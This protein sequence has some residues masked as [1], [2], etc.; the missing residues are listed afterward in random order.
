MFKANVLSGLSWLPLISRIVWAK[1]PPEPRDVEMITKY[2]IQIS[3]A[4]LSVLNVSYLED[5][6]KS[7]FNI[8]I[9]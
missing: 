3:I 9:L 1:N 8:K 6:L 7:S 5:F 2:R 4:L